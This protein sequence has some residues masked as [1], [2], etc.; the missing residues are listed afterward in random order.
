MARKANQAVEYPYGRWQDEEL[1]DKVDAGS[2]MTPNPLSVSPD[3]P[4]FQA[5]KMLSLYKFGA[6]PVV[7]KGALIGI[8]TVTDF[9]DFFA[10]EQPETIIDST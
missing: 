10:T 2:C 4:A 9:L 3:T 7:D 8:V 6:L 5:A 1:L